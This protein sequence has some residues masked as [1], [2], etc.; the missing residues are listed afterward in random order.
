EALEA[1]AIPIILKTHALQPYDYYHNLLGKH[2]L[3]TFSSWQESEAFLRKMDLN[4]IKALSEEIVTWYVSFKADLQSK[5]QKVLRRIAQDALLTDEV[6][7]LDVYA[8]HLHQ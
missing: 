5:V 8:S 1:K 7:C 6:N 2:P 4:S 3:P